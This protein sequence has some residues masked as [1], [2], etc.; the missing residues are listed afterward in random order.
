M[1]VGCP[2]HL[3]VDHHLHDIL[4]SVH[5]GHVDH[6][7]RVLLVVGCVKQV[8]VLLDQ[9]HDAHVAEEDED[10]NL[11]QFALNIRLSG[12]AQLAVYVIL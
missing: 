6:H 4:D 7:L 1:E 8:D 5:G 12:V 3:L 2:G 9:G 10:A 11:Q